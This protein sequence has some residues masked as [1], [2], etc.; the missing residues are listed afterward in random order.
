MRVPGERASA[1]YAGAGAYSV[2]LPIQGPA[3]STQA[4][5]VYLAW[6]WYASRRR[7]LAL[8]GDTTDPI[9]EPGRLE[10]ALEVVGP[11]LHIGE[12]ERELVLSTSRLERYGMG[13]IVQPSGVLPNDIRFVVQGRA[14]IAVE[15][16]GGRIEFATVE[17]GD[18]IGQTALTREKTLTTAVAADVLTVLVVPLA[19]VDELVRKRP[20]L[21]AEIGQSI[22][23]KRKMAA[24]AL[25]SAGIVRGA[26]GGG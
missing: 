19:T 26:L 7:G 16:A 20:L 6:L 3:S 25:A 18:Y 22:E 12:A 9:S 8:D 2:T 21:A 24:E 11:T 1:D 13:E 17:P 14:R 10:H 5:S 4:M 23:L 15:A